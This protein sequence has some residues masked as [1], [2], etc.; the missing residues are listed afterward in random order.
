MIGGFQV[1]PFQTAYQQVGGVVA[2]PGPPAQGGGAR[3]G[4]R[5]RQW[6]ESEPVKK[7]ERS[8]ITE[9]AFLEGERLSTDTS[10]AIEALRAE[11][12]QLRTAVNDAARAKALKKARE[13]AAQA[14]VARAKIERRRSEDAF[15]MSVYEGRLAEL[16]SL[17]E[18]IQMQLSSLF[19]L[20]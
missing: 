12:E 20:N 6:V 1:G 5:I 2:P 7:V 4:R 18:D 16:H 10:R 8:V 9:L 19:K 15:V 17:A 3:R 13:L 11:L 14:A